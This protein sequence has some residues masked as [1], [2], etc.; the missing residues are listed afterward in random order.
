MKRQVNL[1]VPEEINLQKCNDCNFTS[2]SIE[3]FILHNE[4][5]HIEVV[6]SVEL[7]CSKCDFECTD[8]GTLKKH[9]SGNHENSMSDLDMDKIGGKILTKYFCKQC[10]FITD[11]DA[12][13]DAH[14]QTIHEEPRRRKNSSNADSNTPESKTVTKYNCEKCKFSTE[15]S[16]NLTIHMA[17]HHSPEIRF[18]CEKC[19]TK[20]PTEELMKQH[21]I[22]NHT[23]QLFSCDQC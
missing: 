9:N 14:K 13:L 1:L 10:D 8:E 17:R 11:N 6:E 7:C 5:H 16:E 4:T 21:I 12:N 22:Y 3:A 15:D 20:Y 2:L 19:E 23:N 18:V